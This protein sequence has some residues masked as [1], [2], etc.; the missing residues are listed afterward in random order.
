MVAFLG[1]SKATFALGNAKIFRLHLSN[2]PQSLDPQLQKSS[3]SSYVL[4]NLYRN[5]FTFDDEKGLLPDLGV[6]CQRQLKNLQLKC[7]LKPD[8][9]WSD[10]S[11]LTSADFIRTYNRVLDP[12]VGAPRAD[13]L[14][15]I[16]NAKEI[17]Q[18]KA[19]P[20]SLGI[21]AP[22]S[23][24]LI[25]DFSE[26]DPD[27]E[28][29]L[30]S[31]LLSP[32]KEDLKI[33]SGPY[34]LKEFTPGKHIL[35]TPNP[36]YH[37]KNPQRPSVEFLFIEEDSL[38]LQLYEKN[39]LSFLRR[40]PTLFI[41]KYRDSK[42]FHWLSVLRFDYI[43]F[44]PE[45]KDREDIRTA[46]SYSLN[47]TELKKILSSEGLPG[48][49]G[50]PDAWFPDK[51]PCVQFDLAQIPKL[52]NTKNY[53]LMFSSLGG[54]DHK[55]A[56]EW[57]QQQWKKNAQLQVSLEMKENKLYLDELKKNPPALFRKGVS[58]D[59][60]TC[61]AVLETFAPESPE[62]FIQ[63]ADSEYQMILGQ[64]ARAKNIQEQKKFC[65]NGVQF[66][67]NQKRLIPLGAI[68]FAILAKP[69]FVGWKLNQMNQ[70][71]LSGLHL[72][73]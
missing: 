6:S 2:S 15:K 68:H 61:L 12:K 45:L 32:T 42:E 36:E 57:M 40:L 10:G 59:R 47:F 56:T 31:F 62:N 20:E 66:L 5:L 11:P 22:N 51:A 52:K 54:E 37:D 38:A 4:I 60:P 3:A 13:L 48:C 33:T 53:K 70:L 46:F 71:D 35:L 9:H 21:K 50:L 63:L 58:P 41:S 39:E 7:L 30:T 49:A 23:T 43:G 34:L 44:G 67:L 72:K 26:A 69:E 73:P 64:L 28:Y 27:F 18:G 19:K 14:F 25:F 55:R 29:N 16:K 17:Y 1:T 65:L 24:T 8:L